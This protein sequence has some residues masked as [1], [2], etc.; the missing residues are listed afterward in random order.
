[1]TTKNRNSTVTI[2]H[3]SD[4]IFV[5]ANSALLWKFKPNHEY[6]LFHGR[7]GKAIKLTAEELT[8]LAHIID[9]MTKEQ[10]GN[11]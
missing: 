1:M 7:A 4:S 6:T 3:E 10:D 5:H 11:L 8:D 9:A 2:K